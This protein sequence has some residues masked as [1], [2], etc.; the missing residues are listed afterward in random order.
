MTSAPHIFDRALLRRRRERVAA[1]AHDH[2]FLLERVAED[3]AE[4]LEIVK[5]SF[6]VALDLG[7]HHGLLG[8]R[9]AR[10]PNVGQ[11]ISMEAS[12]K[13]LARCD[14]EKLLADGEFFPFGPHTLDLVVSGLS[15]QLVNDLP[16]TLI[17]IRHALKPD[18]L[19][20]ASMLGGATLNEL[21]Q[22]WVIAEDELLGGASPRVAPFADVREM[23]GLLQRAGFALPVVDADVVTVSYPDPISLMLELKQMG[24]SNALLERSRRPATRRLLE[25]AS[26]IYAD[27]FVS[28]N[29][30]VT[31]TFEILTLTAWAPHESQQQP[32]RPGSARS[33]L[34]E[35]LGTKETK[36]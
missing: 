12:A 3:L 13:L 35:A 25:R 20:L 6:P 1:G 8:R 36:L 16:G 4:R 33:R 24:A 19:F 28:S 23:G 2:E 22:A 10:L 7:A 9:I 30:R 27:R 5:R 32:L 18:G 26:A 15:L 14:G 17:Q 29:G 31:A 11:I 34:A 21:R